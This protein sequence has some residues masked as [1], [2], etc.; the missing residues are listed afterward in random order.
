MLPNATQEQKVAT[1]FHRNTMT[2]TEGGTYDEE[3][4]VAAVVD[5][6][7]T[8]MEVWMGT[9]MACAQCHNHK[10][11]PFTQQDYYRL[12]AFFNGT[13][14]RGRSNDPVLP[15]LGPADAARSRA[16]VDELKDVGKAQEA[17]GLLGGGVRQAFLSREA[18]LR[19]ELA[20]FKT[21]TTLIMQE[22]PTPRPTHV[23]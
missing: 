3:F 4:R 11:D 18:A 1:G 20:S 6:V 2:N 15:I 7:N 14:D 23:M 12:F 19:K 16:I 17:S 13:A 21:T 10:F 8:T 5:R 9:T 22:L